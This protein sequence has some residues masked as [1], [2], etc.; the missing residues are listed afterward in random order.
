MKKDTIQM[1]WIIITHTKVWNEERHRINETVYC[2][3]FEKK[4]HKPNA[5]YTI[6]ETVLNRSHFIRWAFRKLA[7]Y[8]YMFS[9]I[10]V[11]LNL[12]P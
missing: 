8:K 4:T 10:Y 3:H 11:I 5:V 6:D 2:G 7:N 9:Y 1:K 12:C